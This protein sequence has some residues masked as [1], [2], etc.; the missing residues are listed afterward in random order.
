MEVFAWVCNYVDC[1]T[2][3]IAI[4][5]FEIYGIAR[6]QPQVIS[7]LRTYKTFTSRPL[8]KLK[9]RK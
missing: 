4:G 3:V 5:A 6:Y 9:H 1:D 2:Y 7:H 8:K